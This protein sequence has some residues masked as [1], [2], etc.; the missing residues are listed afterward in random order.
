ML[1]RLR[2]TLTAHSLGP[3]AVLTEAHTLC[4]IPFHTRPGAGNESCWP[5]QPHRFLVFQQPLPSPPLPQHTHVLW[6]W[7]VIGILMW[8]LRTTPWNRQ[9]PHFPDEETKEVRRHPQI[10][11]KRACPKFLPFDLCA[12]LHPQLLLG[13][14]GESPPYCPLPSLAGSVRPVSSSRGT[15][16]ASCVCCR[17]ARTEV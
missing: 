5:H 10:K 13:P 11:A 15:S 7:S 8:N 2:S 12:V 9:Y 16:L 6:T 4:R 17:L 14:Q 1:H 3:R